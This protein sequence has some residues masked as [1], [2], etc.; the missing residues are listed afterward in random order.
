MYISM[1]FCL[2][3]TSVAF[4]RSMDVAIANFIYKFLVVYQDVLT[5]CSKKEN[6]HYMHL[7]KVFTGALE[8]GNQFIFAY[9]IRNSG[10]IE[11][12]DFYQ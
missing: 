11:T 7:E 4:Q 8:P 10:T 3:N 9:I 12:R 2:T 5:K 1:P 6:D